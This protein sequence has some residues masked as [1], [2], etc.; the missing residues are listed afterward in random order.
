MNNELFFSITNHSLTIV[1]ADALYV[2][3]FETDVV[4]ITPGQTTNVLLKTKHYYP[5]ATFIMGRQTI[6]Y[7]TR[8]V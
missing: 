6:L 4:F 5:N 1:E 8:H 7:G 2:K 3:P